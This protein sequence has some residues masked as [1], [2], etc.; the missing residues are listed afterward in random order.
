M[1]VCSNI[2]RAVHAFSV[3]IEWQNVVL[4]IFRTSKTGHHIIRRFISCDVLYCQVKVQ[5]P[6][7][8]SHPWEE[9]SSDTTVPILLVDM[10]LEES[11]LSPL[12]RKS[13][14]KK[15]LESITETWLVGVTWISGWYTIWS[16]PHTIIS[17]SY[18]SRKSEIPYTYKHIYLHRYR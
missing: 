16:P 17:V 15:E 12:A 14:K 8:W 13:Q 3:T 2:D 9:A 18:Y 7:G 6:D 10:L 5:L 4:H 11:Q 1:V